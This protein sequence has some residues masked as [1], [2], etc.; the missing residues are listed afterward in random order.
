MSDDTMSAGFKTA[1][2]L[3]T[4]EKA[5]WF[6]RILINT[7]R[8]GA[9]GDGKSTR[10]TAALHK[11]SDA[12]FTTYQRVVN[13]N[14][15]SE[16]EK[17]L[18][19]DSVL[20]D[21]LF[22]AYPEGEKGYETALEL[23]TRLAVFLK[24]PKDYYI[25]AFTIQKLLVPT[26]EAVAKIPMGEPTEYAHIYAK[27]VLDTKREQGLA[28]LIREW[29]SMT[30]DLALN[31]E[32]DIIVELFGKVRAS[33]GSDIPESEQ[34]TD[35]DTVSVLTAISQE[36]ERRAGQKRKGR[37]GR[38]LE[39]AT[40]YIFK[41]FG[42]KPHGGPAH[43]DAAVEVDN[44]LMDKNGWYIG[45]SLKRTLRERWKQVDAGVDVMNRFHIK[46]I[47]H[48]INN[49]KDLSDSKIAALGASRHLFFIAD[50][51][52]VLKQYGHHVAMGQYLFP[53]SQLIS[54]VNELI[55]E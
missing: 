4:W 11:L 17:V 28:T 43:F 44:W 39:G 6:L 47:I 46:H 8:F 25:F 42:L 1:E 10:K 36:Y 7:D 34:L 27:A 53:M 15:H 2:D 9:F 51:S 30:E 26:N 16:A 23:H 32:R 13:A 48:L 50:D 52:P 45:V 12:L 33:L 20:K 37:A 5:Y 14:E 22:G 49:D 54:K 18:I 19:L 31:K 35:F 55:N 24:E 38:D 40:D 41:Y 21:I 3:K 29:D